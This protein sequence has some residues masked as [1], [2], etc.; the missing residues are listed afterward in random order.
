MDLFLFKNV[1]ASGARD[2]CVIARDEWIAGTTCCFLRKQPFLMNFGYALYFNLPFV[3]RSFILL[4][5]TVYL[6]NKFIGLLA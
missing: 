3:I 5:I 4:Y 1:L 2:V 6:H